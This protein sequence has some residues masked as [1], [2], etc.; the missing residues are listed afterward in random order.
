MIR[1]HSEV[2]GAVL[3]KHEQDRDPLGFGGHAQDVT[4]LPLLRSSCL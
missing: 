3:S 2:G 1:R 4:Q